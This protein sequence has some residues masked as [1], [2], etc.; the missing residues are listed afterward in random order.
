MILS[1]KGFKTKRKQ[2]FGCVVLTLFG[3]FVHG[4]WFVNK[5]PS[6]HS[7]HIDTYSEAFACVRSSF[8]QVISSHKSISAFT[9]LSLHFIYKLCC[10]VYLFFLPE[11]NPDGK[12]IDLDLNTGNAHM[13]PKSRKNH[14]Y[15]WPMLMCSCND[16]SL[17]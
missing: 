6:T 1:S 2:R 4:I 9:T 15:L 11:K 14:K 10:V 7:K 5:T 17:R 12:K 8:E 16:E 13:Q 3:S